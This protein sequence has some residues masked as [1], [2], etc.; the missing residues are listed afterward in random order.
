MPKS[1]KPLYSVVI[2]AFNEEGSLGALVKEI[3]RVMNR[4][5]SPFEIIVVDDGSTDGTGE[6]L[7][8][9]EGIRL[10]SMRA[11]FGQSTALSVG[12]KAAYGKT[13]ITLDGDGQ[14]DPAD[15]PKLLQKLNQGHDVVCG[16]RY[17]RKD[18]WDKI[19]VSTVARKLRTVLVDDGV[20]D[21]GCTLRVFKKECFDD[22]DLS[23]EIHRMI[24]AILRWRGFDVAELKVNHRPRL[25]GKSKYGAS[26]TVKGF[27]DMLLVWFTR[28]YNSRPLHLFGGAGL[29]LILA[30]SILLMALAWMKIFKG[31][32]L[33]N[34]IWPLVGA[35]GL[36]AGLQLMVSGVLAD[37][38]IK[39]NTKGKSWMIKDVSKN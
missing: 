31:Y 28:K 25:T 15:I 9:T 19:L 22:L 5:D 34:K 20:H 24:P 23:G 16:W 8:M 38:I 10:I 39:N 32:E 17:Q 6:I 26:R 3:K 27:L 14:N 13:L 30:S 18:S 11:N 1:L 33:S 12:I 4:L 35:M 36:L 29:L 37:L 7:R 2:P 21:A